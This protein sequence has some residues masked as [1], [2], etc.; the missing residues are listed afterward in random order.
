MFSFVTNPTITI[1]FDGEDARAK[2]TMKVQGGDPITVPVY[3]GQELVNGVVDISVPPGKKIDHQGIR[4][5]MIGQTGMQHS[6]VS[7]S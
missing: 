5:E 6:Y 4:I 1:T 7:S 3:T 2:K